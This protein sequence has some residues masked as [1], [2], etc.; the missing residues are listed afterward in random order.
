VADQPDY[1]G[2]CMIALYPPPGLAADLAVPGGLHASE[3]HCTVVYTGDAADVDPEALKAVAEILARRD[4]VQAVISGHARFT[5]GDQDV[6]VAL[7]SSPALDDLHRD[8]VDRLGARGITSPSAYGYCPH[9]TL[10]YLATDDP[11]P[12]GRVATIPVTFGAVSVMHGSDRTDYPFAASEQAGPAVVSAAREAYAAGWALSGG[13]MTPR[14]RAGCTAAVTLAVDHWDDPAVLETILAIGLLEGQQAAIADRA[15]TLLAA[16]LAV[17]LDAWRTCVHSLNAR[18]L[19]SRYRAA[20]YLPRETA[21][22]AQK[23]FRRTEAAAVALGWLRGIYQSRGHDALLAAIEAALLAA[24]AEGE[25]GALAMAAAMDGV[26]GFDTGTAYQAAHDRLAADPQLPGRARDLLDVIITG[27]AAD[28]ARV[29]AK[30]ADDD[31]SYEDMLGA[32]VQA[33]GGS[34]V[35]AVDVL[36][37]N[38]IWAAIGGG[39]L[40]LWRRVADAAAG[41]LVEVDWEAGPSACTA[42]QDNADGGPYSP[43]NVPAYPCHPGCRCRLASRSRIPASFLRLGG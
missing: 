2:S 40:S 36:G 25:A 35:R 7:A 29:L 9:L 23:E 3:M 32:A 21:D 38:G 1:S 37:G 18:K 41:V 42:C 33:A 31:G 43:S 26:T 24:A 39:A 22:P 28:L 11:D 34:E 16:H 17:I 12:V 27:A 8:A 4:P 19:I 15:G 6:I 20:I 5:G 14:V 10:R 30:Q 13:P